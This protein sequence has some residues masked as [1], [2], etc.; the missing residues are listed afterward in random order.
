MQFG[1]CGDLSVAAVAARESYD[2]A[3]TTVAD[4]LMPRKSEDVFCLSLESLRAAELP[5]PVANGFV[6][7]DLKITG[8]DVDIPALQAF[9]TTTMQ[10]AERAGVQVVVFGS[11]DARRVPAGFDPRRAHDQLV[12]F[13]GLVAPLAHE[14][15]VTVVVEH[16]NTAECNILTTVDECAGLVN[17]VAHP[18]IQLLVDAYHLMHDNDSYEAIVAHGGIIAHAHIATMPNRLAPG[19]EPSDFSPFFTAL[20]E[21]RY[22]GRISIE[23]KYADP[24]IELPVALAV[25]RSLA[26]S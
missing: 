4:L 10:R 26:G 13:C 7:G 19:V 6:P 20:A 16:L 9:V 22:T 18:A 2:Y 8:P 24:K 11:G 17:D 15:G 1:M 23:A 5:Y 14:H 12:A 3:E 25:M 21:A